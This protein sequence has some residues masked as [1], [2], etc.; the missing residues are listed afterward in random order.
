MFA[1]YTILAK[2]CLVA[3]SREIIAHG[4]LIADTAFVMETARAP[5]DGTSPSEGEKA[6]G[7]GQMKTK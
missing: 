5:R 6:E 1:Y 4:R 2:N 3:T 7:S